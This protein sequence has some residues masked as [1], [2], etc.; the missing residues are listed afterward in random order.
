MLFVDITKG[1]NCTSSWG[2]IA[3]KAS[4]QRQRKESLGK[5]GS[6]NHGRCVFAGLD[7]AYH[8]GNDRSDPGVSVDVG[9]CVSK[10]MGSELHADES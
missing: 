4:W 3:L 7:G 5:R 6:R 1:K 8:T 9:F 2:H 10:Q